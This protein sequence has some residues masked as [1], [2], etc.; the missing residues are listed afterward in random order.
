MSFNLVMDG[1]S[2]NL[3]ESF[4]SCKTLGELN[5][6]IMEDLSN[7]TY[8]K[9]LFINIFIHRIRRGTDDSYVESCGEFANAEYY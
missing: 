3:K 7:S 4:G 5:G 2:Q 1:E 9:L 8:C 6:D